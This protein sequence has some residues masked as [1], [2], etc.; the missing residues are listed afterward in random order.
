MIGFTPICPAT[1]PSNLRRN[2]FDWS[3]SLQN[4]SFVARH[5]ATKLKCLK[6]HIYQRI[7][8]SI[9]GFRSFVAGGYFPPCFWGKKRGGV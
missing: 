1:K 7:I 3:V 5:F 8:S 4:L 9:E 2:L 6:S